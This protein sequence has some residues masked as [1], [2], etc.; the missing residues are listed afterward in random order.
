MK[1]LHKGIYVVVDSAQNLETM[2]QQLQQ[3]TGEAIAAVQIWDNPEAEQKLGAVV[4]KVLQ[5]W[6]DSSVPVLI[7]NK[8]EMLK[9]YALDG[10][11]FDAL[12]ANW[13]DIWAQLPRNA[14]TG[15]TLENDLSVVEQDA[16][17]DYY[18][19]CSVFPSPTVTSCEIVR[20]ETI[21]QCRKLTPKPL[22]LAGGIN[23]QN[24]S[25]L[26]GLPFDGV[27]VISAVMNHP[28]PQQIV[29]ELVAQLG[30]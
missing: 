3:I 6:E 16:P 12:P 29:R 8:W 21:V 13:Q 26:R 5:I 7:N 1:Q 25:E 17:V 23:A 2:T 18:S 24:L 27:A 14:I 30:D 28:H 10:V 22:Y 20:P 9:E 11:H 19:F 4:E 15:L